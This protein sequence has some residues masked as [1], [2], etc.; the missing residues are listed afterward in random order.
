MNEEKVIGTVEEVQT[1]EGETDGKRWT[2]TAYKVTGRIFST[3]DD[4]YSSFKEGDLVLIEYK[5]SLDGKYNNITEMF[6]GKFST[7]KV[8]EDYTLTALFELI[9]EKIRQELFE[10]LRNNNMLKTREL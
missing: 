9:R 8:L 6:K 1:K 10:E 4:K 5:K 7:G 2:R 3:F